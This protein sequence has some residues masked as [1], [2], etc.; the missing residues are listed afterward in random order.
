MTTII[1]EHEVYM[2]ISSISGQN[3]FNGLSSMF[4]THKYP[5]NYRVKKPGF[6]EPKVKTVVVWPDGTIDTS[7]FAKVQQWIDD[8]IESALLWLA[9]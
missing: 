3:N 8:R 5:R 6:K 2:Q 1:E 4:K 7:R 9:R